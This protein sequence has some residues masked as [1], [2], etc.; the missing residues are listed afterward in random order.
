MLFRLPDLNVPFN[1][2]ISGTDSGTERT[3]SSSLMALS[4]VVQLTQQKE[5]IPSK[6]NWTLSKSGCTLT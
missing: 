3:L 1:V 2:F 6:G 5:G 4:G